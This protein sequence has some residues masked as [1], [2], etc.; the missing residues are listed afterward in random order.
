MK[1]RFSLIA[2]FLVSFMSAQQGTFSP[3]SYFGLGD[4]APKSLIENRGMAG[5]SMLGDSIHM[6]LQNPAA[7]ANLR[8]TTY[9]VGANRRASVLSSLEEQIDDTKVDRGH[10]TN[11]DYL[12]LALP[13]SPKGA[14]S[15][16]IMPYSA[17]S[18]QIGQTRLSM[19]T[20]TVRTTFEGSGGINR[21]FASL[22]YQ[23]FKGVNA[24]VMAHYNWGTKESRRLQASDQVQFGTSD[25]RFSRIKGIDYT[26]AL[27][28]TI[29]F[30]FKQ[31]K[32]N[33]HTSAVYDFAYQLDAS[34][35]Q[36][37]GS[38]LVSTGADREV[39]NVDLGSLENSQI[40]MPSKTTLGF[41][42][43][44]PFHWFIGA[45]YATQDMSFF[46]NEFI[47]PVN[48][49]YEMAT[50]L[51]VGGYFVPNYNALNGILNRVT[52]R[53][54]LRIEDTGLRLN[55]T[56]I[57]MVVGSMGFSLPMGSTSADRFSSINVALEYGSRGTTNNGLL[58]ESFF[59][60]NIGLSLN[61]RWF[62]KRR[63]N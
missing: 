9:A 43:G 36:I 41:G 47:E 4:V 30:K 2:L 15:F 25:Q 20:D 46:K 28:V 14:F 29:P 31:S 11:L 61:D 59:G 5:V 56:P 6:N 52:Y 23:L 16:G 55:Q 53:A 26:S 1:L 19:L 45:E 48:S 38:F 42:L 49:S 17:T 32:L 40:E 50:S 44:K 27:T 35:E 22:G 63:I 51:K 33:L 3:Y 13:L 21:V 62:V 12:A 54:G 37:F 8:L 18:Y 10:I 34:N 39:F 60:I 24:G 58:K 57:E 7:L